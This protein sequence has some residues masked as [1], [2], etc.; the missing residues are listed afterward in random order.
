MSNKVPFFYLCGPVTTTPNHNA[1][2][3][4]ETTKKLIQK[5]YVVYNPV[6]TSALF[7][8]ESRKYQRKTAKKIIASSGLFVLPEWSR[9]SKAMFEIDLARKFFL[10]IYDTTKI[11]DGFRLGDALLRENICT[12]A[13][14][15]VFK[16]RGS[17][18]MHPLDDYSCTAALWSAALHSAKI[19][20]AD[21][22][23]TPEMAQLLMILVKV[24]RAS[25]NITH[26]DNLVDIAGYAECIQ[27]TIEERKRRAAQQE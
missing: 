1:D 25:R 24:S 4:N 7:G 20:D 10:P 2:V 22:E 8:I 5:N 11:L 14:R 26:R 23:I 18:Y 9:C 13:E 16:D 3:F 12:E 21:K 19:L 6:E 27:L 17:A 15:L